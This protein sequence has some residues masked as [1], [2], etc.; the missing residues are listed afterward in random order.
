M[1]AIFTWTIRAVVPIPRPR[2]MLA[3]SIVS[4]AP[5]LFCT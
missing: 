1:G 5:L 4:G 3:E 2:S